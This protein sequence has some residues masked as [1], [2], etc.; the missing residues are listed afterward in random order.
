MTSHLRRKRRRYAGFTMIELLVVIAIIAI[1]IGLLLPAVQKVR[2]AA[3]RAKCQNNLKQIG[4]ALHSYHEAFGLFPYATAN[5]AM[6]FTAAG[7]Q[8]NNHSGWPLLLPYLDQGPLYNKYDFTAAERNSLF[9]GWS[10]SS[11]GTVVGLPAAIT[12][13]QELSKTILNVLSCP[14]DAGMMSYPSVTGYYGCN[15][16]GSQ[17]INY[18]FS[19]IN[20]NPVGLWLNETRVT[21]ALFGQNSNSQIRDIKDGTSNTAMIVETTREVWDGNG[22]V[23]GCSQYAGNGVILSHSRGINDIICCGWDTPPN[24]RARIQGKNGSFNLPGS[25]HVGGCQAA[26]ADG[27]VRFLSDSM[28]AATRRNVAYI[29]DGQAISDF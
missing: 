2:D 7:D 9:S 16:A 19:V 11:S 24:S 26:M 23:W 25:S 1:L 29:A 17:L 15:V 12:A 21:R 20:G 8:V 6:Q 22:N 10:S 27:A 18:G 14:S 3:A 4:I 28:D 5:N 13:N